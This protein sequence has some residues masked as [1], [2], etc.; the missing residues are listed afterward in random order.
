MFFH[1]VSKK[2]EFDQ[3]K[4]GLTKQIAE[5]ENEKYTYK[6]TLHQNERTITELKFQLKANEIEKIQNENVQNQ[7]TQMK[8]QFHKKVFYSF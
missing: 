2:K 4:I 8:I 6:Q 1:S 5:L 7:L 3:W